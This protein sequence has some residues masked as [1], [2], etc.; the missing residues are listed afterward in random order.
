[1]TPGV[2]CLVKRVERKNRFG[3]ANKGRFGADKV[4]SLGFRQSC[5][6][7]YSILL[8]MRNE[9]LY[10]N[11]IFGADS[12]LFYCLAWVVNRLTALYKR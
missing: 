8:D 1:M 4:V 9:P 11:T 3:T 5:A 12:F 7:D 2:E 10:R 6:A